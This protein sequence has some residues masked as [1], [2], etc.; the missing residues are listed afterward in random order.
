MPGL[1]QLFTPKTGGIEH[2]KFRSD[3]IKFYQRRGHVTESSLSR[4]FAISLE[5]QIN[6]VV[7]EKLLTNVVL[8]AFF[9]NCG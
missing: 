5:M 2:C 8:I 4:E 7:R 3:S 1:I 6:F 9:R